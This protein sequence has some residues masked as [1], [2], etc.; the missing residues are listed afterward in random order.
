MAAKMENGAI[1]DISMVCGAVECTPRRLTDV[2]SLVRGEKPGQ[3][4]ETLV[5]RVA[6]RGAEPLN[7]N[8]FK[9]PLMENLAVRAIRS[10][11]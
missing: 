5:K 9:I 2:E 6:S 11:A 10:L 1:S 8:H 4:L 3:E 7:F